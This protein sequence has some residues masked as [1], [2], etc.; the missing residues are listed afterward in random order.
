MLTNHFF[1]PAGEVTPNSGSVGVFQKLV[2][3][4]AQSVLQT[5]DRGERF[6]VFQKLKFLER[7][8]LYL[9]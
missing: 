3:R 9:L 8:H 5:K 2:S 4:G 7:F 6:F 1:G